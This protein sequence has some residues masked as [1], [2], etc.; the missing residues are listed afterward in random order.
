M[1]TTLRVIQTI[2]DKK[3]NYQKKPCP[4]IKITSRVYR[5]RSVACSAFVHQL[6]D[7]MPAF[8]GGGA[9]TDGRMG[10]SYQL[11]VEDNSRPIGENEDTFVV[12]TITETNSGESP[13]GMRQMIEANRKT[14]FEEI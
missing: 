11:F 7:G 2:L 9:Y 10:V 14:Y 3:T 1:L 13:D 8:C 4:D 12:E 6:R 5:L